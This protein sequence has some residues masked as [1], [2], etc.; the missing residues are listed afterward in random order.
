MPATA[1]AAPERAAPLSPAVGQEEPAGARAAVHIQHRAGDVLG[2]RRGQEQHRGGDLRRLAHPP[3]RDRRHQR[4]PVPRVHVG[5]PPHIDQARRDDVDMDPV[6]GEFLRKHLAEHDDPRFGRAVM[7]GAPARRLVGARGDVH[8]VPALAPGN[9]PSR[10]GAGHQ[11]RPFQV[12]IHH[13]VPLVLGHL[14]DRTVGVHARVIDQD[15]HL[16][17]AP[18]RFLDDS[19]DPLGRADVPG[20]GNGPPPAAVEHPDGL[21]RPVPVKIHHGDRGPLPREGRGDPPADPAAGAGDEDALPGKIA[22][23]HLA[24]PIVCVSA[25]AILC[26]SR[27]L[28]SCLRPRPP[29]SGPRRRPVRRFALVRRITAWP[30][31]HAP[32]GS[33]RMGTTTTIVLILIIIGLLALAVSLAQAVAA[34]PRVPAAHGPGAAV[35]RDLGGRATPPK[36]GWNWGA[37]FLGPVWYLLQG[38]WTYTIIFTFMLMLS[39]GIL[40]PF[41]MVYA[42]LKA[43]ETLE[44]ARLARHSVY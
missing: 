6:L 42:G 4:L 41:V 14:D 38:L 7:R 8:D 3:P 20:H 21:L 23:A 30:A 34:Y 5:P 33:A 43:N 27:D 15:I 1:A 36:L 2:A 32:E 31:W 35:E 11:E 17:E 29:P 12:G 28:P 9:H 10:H 39:G 25:P 44:D 16:A 26:L 24:P 40:L 37:F 19:I 13:V 22:I 18:G